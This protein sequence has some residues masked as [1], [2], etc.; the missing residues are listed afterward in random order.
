MSTA[1]EICEGVS[2]S[3]LDSPVSDI[4]LSDIASRI[5]EWQELA[6]YLDLSEVEEKDIVDSYPS[7]PKLQRREALRKWKESNGDKA[8]YRRLI[9]VLCSQGRIGT[10]QTLKELLMRAKDPDKGEEQALV[11]NF[12]K[13]LCDC[14]S[15]HD[16]PSCLQ[17]PF[18][19]NQEFVELDLFDAPLNH[20]V[21]D[22]SLK[23]LSVACI[24]DA[25]DRT[26]KR[27]VVFV[28]G[29]AGAGKSTLCWYIRKEWATGRKFEAFRLLIHISLSDTGIHFAKKL[30]DLIPHPSEEMREGV[31]KAIADARG[32]GTC[33]LLDA[34]DEAKQFSRSTFL[35]QFIAGTG[36]RSMLPF[37]TLLLTSRPGI[38]P[39][40]LK[41]ATGHIVVKGFKSL[42]EYIE[43]VFSEHSMK[44]AQLFEALQ[45]KP[46]LYSLCQLPLHAVILVHIFDFLKSELPTT[47]TGLFHPLV[48]NF[49]IRHIQT[50][51][52]HQ[53]SS[54]CDLS[55]DL[56]SDVYQ[57]LCKV[58]RLAFQSLINGDIVIT[59][60][61]LTRLTKVKPALHDSFGFLQSYQRV[62]M[63][64]PTNLYKFSH[65]SLQEFLA[66][67]HIAQLNEV[68]QFSA[69]Q[70]VYN[71]NP[72]SPILTFYA[73]LTKLASE[74]AC[75]LLFHVLTKRLDLNSTVVELQKT[76][77]PVHDIRRQLLALVNCLYET[78]KRDLISHAV[79]TPKNLEDRVVLSSAFYAKICSDNTNIEFP[80][81]YMVLYPTD[82]LSIGYFVRLISKQ[83][84]K[85]NTIYLNMESSF[86]GP[87]EIKALCQELH[88]PSQARRLYLNIS[89]MFLTN[90]AIDAINTVLRSD[91]G[92]DGLIITG[93]LIYDMQ[94]ALKY[95]I[96][97]QSHCHACPYVSITELNVQL[98]VS[99]HLVLLLRCDCLS[100]LDLSGSKMLFKSREVMLLFCKALSY[101]SIRRL[102]L[103]S[104][105]INDWGLRALATAISGGRCFMIALDIGWNPYTAHGLKS[106]LKILLRR[107]M[108]TCIQVLSTSLVHS[109]HRK[110][111]QDLNIIR[112][113]FGV[114]HELIIECKDELCSREK[115]RNCKTFLLSQPQ[116]IA[117]RTHH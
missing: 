63:F 38:P 88:K 77:H 107:F 52:E 31:A 4:H 116:L 8:T 20:I 80:F 18:S 109:K 83:V 32:K 16:H 59:Q 68:D 114:Y 22:K 82:C 50:R 43:R 102:L 47:R 26:T 84:Q 41:R 79:L 19:T 86:V 29:V 44:R 57:A 11:E 51:T 36:S 111:V 92:L 85:S 28:E 54:V 45:M 30:A 117:R 7:R 75:K 60:G 55:S 2:R 25:G 70:C 87:L 106:F 108:F 21:D 48:C 39:D 34:C 93:C 97:A 103:D 24:F 15:N 100:T 98:P 115:D 5:T 1:K 58:S 6:P 74:N 99:H 49:L 64:G 78:Q 72:V 37:A 112:R 33:F 40:L 81:M 13:Y 9:C 46:E 110:L 3:L 89:D 96:E 62:T 76:I 35:Y 71:Q 17:W 91:A 95:I 67:F 27:K 101:S 69:F 56:P 10:A 113:H 61:M 66:A 104:C 65:L 90:E 53:L 14:Y 23:P 42:D 73:G 12:C 105:G 94:L